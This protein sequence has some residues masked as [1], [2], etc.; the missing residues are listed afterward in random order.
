MMNVLGQMRPDRR[1]W[2]PPPEYLELF[3]SPPKKAEC[4]FYLHCE[5]GANTH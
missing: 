2:G 5:G 4:D 1:G 3:V